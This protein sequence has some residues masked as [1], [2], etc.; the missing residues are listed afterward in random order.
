M[1]GNAWNVNGNVVHSVDNKN[2]CECV[3]VVC[4]SEDSLHCGR[5]GTEAAVDGSRRGDEE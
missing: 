5:E 1:K 4:P 2:M 3:C